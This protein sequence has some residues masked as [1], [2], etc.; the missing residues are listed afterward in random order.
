MQATTL[1]S[2]PAGG[3]LRG[4]IRSTEAEHKPDYRCKAADDKEAAAHS[5]VFACNSMSMSEGIHVSAGGRAPMA[6]RSYS[7][8]PEGLVRGAGQRG[9]SGALQSNSP[10][11]QPHEPVQAAY[12]T[13]CDPIDKHAAKEPAQVDGA[14][15]LVHSPLTRAVEREELDGDALIVGSCNGFTQP[16]EQQRS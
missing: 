15:L 7:S 4:S 12:A 8:S 5:A 10:E 16:T 11:M 2:A 14:E 13:A 3:C 6:G 9:S 1:A